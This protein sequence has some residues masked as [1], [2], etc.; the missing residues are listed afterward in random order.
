MPKSTVFVINLTI[1]NAVRH[2]TYF[3]FQD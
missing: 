1:R 2:F 3:V